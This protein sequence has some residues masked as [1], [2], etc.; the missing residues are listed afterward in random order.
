MVKII[1]LL[2]FLCLSAICFSQQFKEVT[3]YNDSICLRVPVNWVY[4]S[5]YRTYSNYEI[6]YDAKY[7]NKNGRK[8]L[9]LE[10]V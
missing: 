1:T 10:S 9:L 4:H 3:M 7:S 5:N 8:A 6:V 2:F